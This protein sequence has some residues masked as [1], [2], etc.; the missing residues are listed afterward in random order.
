MAVLQTAAFPLGYFDIT[1]TERVK[2]VE[3]SAS[4]LA[5]KRSPTELHLQSTE[6]TAGIEPARYGLEGQLTAE[7]TFA[8]NRAV[9][10]NRTRE[11]LLGKEM[12]YHWATTAKN[13]R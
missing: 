12:P 9:D 4:S 11:I 7:V 1:T 8:N 10:G 2:G 6:R 5:R 3:P 13:F